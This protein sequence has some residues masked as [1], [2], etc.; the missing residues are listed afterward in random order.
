MTSLGLKPS[1]VGEIICGL[2]YTDYV[3]GPENNKSRSGKQS[4]QVWTF[5]KHI[6]NVDIYIKVH[7]VSTKQYAKCVCIS[8][9][10][11]DYYMQYPYK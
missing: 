7:L 10:K 1:D 9:H 3:Y 8:F 5:G 6:E 2:I 4:G 11:A